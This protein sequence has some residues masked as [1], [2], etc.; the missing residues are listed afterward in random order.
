ML[1]KRNLTFPAVRLNRGEAVWPFPQ[2]RPGLAA[3]KGRSRRYLRKASLLELTL[4]E[5]D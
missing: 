5:E 3:A 1:L 2:L 4:K